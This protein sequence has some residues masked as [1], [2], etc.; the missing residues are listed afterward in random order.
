M[1]WMP[2]VIA[3][4]VGVLCGLLWWRAFFRPSAKRRPPARVSIVVIARTPHGF[5]VSRHPIASMSE[6]SQN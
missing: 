1:S 6:D 2:I 4:E 5:A 3:F